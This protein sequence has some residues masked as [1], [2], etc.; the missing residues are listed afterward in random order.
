MILGLLAALA[1]SVCYGVATVL[2]AVSARAA[3]HTADVDPRL[4][5][6]LSRQ[7]PFVAGMA[8]D[9]I[10]F[11]LQ[12]LALRL[13]PVFLVQAAMS[14]NL[15]VTALLAVPVL[16]VRLGRRDWT[17]MAMVCVGLAL[18]AL[19]AGPEGHREPHGAARLILPAC[20][21]VLGVAGFAAGRLPDP[22][23]SAVLGAVAGL[24]FGVVALAARMLPGFAPGRLIS[25]PAT[26]ALVGGGVTAFLFFAT[27]L[28]RGA[29]T[30]TTAAVVVGETTVPAAVGVIWL[31]DQVR[32][33]FV[34]VGL[35]G[36]LLALTGA[37]LLTRFGEPVA[38][39]VAEPVPQGG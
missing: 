38:E 9:V 28:Q 25:E 16:R 33:G 37:L 35:T 6:R 14:A 19:S 27:G 32:R 21:L 3:P 18:L 36:F 11:G 10:G 30:V 22:A 15:A 5:L 2:Q 26:Y 39:P 20:V 29:V 12:F 4:L 31:G 13:V 23:R 8:L 24:G 1:A 34:P 17:A 7:M